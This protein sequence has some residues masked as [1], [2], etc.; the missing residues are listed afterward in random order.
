MPQTIKGNGPE[1][2]S[3]RLFLVRLYSELDY[4]RDCVNLVSMLNAGMA[5]QKNPM[6]G[7]WTKAAK[8]R[9][10]FK[11]GR[12]RQKDRVLTP[13]AAVYE[14]CILLDDL[15]NAMA[16][17]GLERDDVRAALVLMTPETQDREHV[18]YVLR[19]PQ[20]N[21]L[22]SVFAELEKIEKPGKILP[23][24]LAVWQRD[25]E[26][27]DTPGVVWAQP[28]LTGDRATRALRRAGELFRDGK[29]G[30]ANFN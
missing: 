5:K 28:F 16:D 12:Q 19:M 25:R 2:R 18:V 24:G 14:A 7:T 27:E 3:A 23:L 30:H 29:D 26:L 20:P 9:R 21:Q 22:P 6:A 8:V 13:I 17:A 1:I 15:R 10:A 11:A 4:S